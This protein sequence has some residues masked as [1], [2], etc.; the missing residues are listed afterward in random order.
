MSRPSGQCIV[1]KGPEIEL[2]AESGPY[3]FTYFKRFHKKPE[4]KLTVTRP[5][6]RIIRGV[7]RMTARRPSSVKPS[8]LTYGR[9]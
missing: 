4:T 9:R 3:A 2:Q 6:P 7:K 1:T 8:T 5:R